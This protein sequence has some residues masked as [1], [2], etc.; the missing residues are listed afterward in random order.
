MVEQHDDIHHST[1]GEPAEPT[2]RCPESPAQRSQP[3]R[4]CT[5]PQYR[6]ILHDDDLNE[7][8]FVIQALVR[9]TPL[10]PSRATL[11]ML[12]AQ[13]N[14]TALVTITHRER[15]ELYQSLLEGRGLTVSIEPDA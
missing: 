11:V 2:S 10:T 1:V 13:H 12:H 7:M 15:A 5:L 8:T 14:G 3:G 6:V 9:Y 4:R